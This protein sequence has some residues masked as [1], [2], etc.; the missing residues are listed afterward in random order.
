MTSDYDS[1]YLL[2]LCMRCNWDLKKIRAALFS[3]LISQTHANKRKRKHKNLVCVFL[4][5]YNSQLEKDPILIAYQ[6]SSIVVEFPELMNGTVV[7]H[8]TQQVGKNLEVPL[9]RPVQHSHHPHSSSPLPSHD[10]WSLWK[11]FDFLLLVSP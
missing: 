8:C 9:P 10:V 3:L 4:W 11:L 7:V 2:T 5:L 6:G 1:S